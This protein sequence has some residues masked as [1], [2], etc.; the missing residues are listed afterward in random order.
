MAPQ[1]TAMNEL[2]F[3]DDKAWMICEK[4]SLPT[5]LSPT[6]NTLKSV[7]ATCTATLSAW[8]NAGELPM[9]PNLFFID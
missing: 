3:R 6:I 2:C 5:P 8:F 1:F 7:E 9:M 4:T